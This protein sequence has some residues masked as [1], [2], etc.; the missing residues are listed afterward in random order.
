MLEM[1][2]AQGMPMSNPR[3]LSKDDLVPREV[4]VTIMLHCYARA[5][6]ELAM[7]LLLSTGIFD[8]AQ[9]C[10]TATMDCLRHRQK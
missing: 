5:A 4:T 10:T 1:R 8:F 2:H 9:H 6:L 7:L 3:S